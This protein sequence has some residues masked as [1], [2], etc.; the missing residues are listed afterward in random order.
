MFRFL[1]FYYCLHLIIEMTQLAASLTYLMKALYTSPSNILA[2]DSRS[3]NSGFRRCCNFLTV[4]VVASLF[5]NRYINT[6]SSL[7]S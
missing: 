5:I 4:M 3:L 2:F 1:C 6:G 7:A